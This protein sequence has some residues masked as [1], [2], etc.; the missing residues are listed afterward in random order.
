MKDGPSRT[1]KSAWANE[2]AIRIRA[3][4]EGAEDVCNFMKAVTQCQHD[5]ANR[6]AGYQ[7]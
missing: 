3:K 2:A 4:P 5:Q 1:R 7:T 6:Y